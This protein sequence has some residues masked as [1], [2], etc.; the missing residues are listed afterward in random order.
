[1]K[2]KEKKGEEEEEGEKSQVGVWCLY[3][4]LFVCCRKERKWEQATG[5]KIRLMCA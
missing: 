3:V 1:M 2:K 5:D 4:C